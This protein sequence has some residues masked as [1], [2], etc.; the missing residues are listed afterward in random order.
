MKRILFALLFILSYSSL[1][2]QNPAFKIGVDSFELNGKPF[3]IHCGE[4]HFAR[5]P[6]AEW[7]NRLKM[8]KE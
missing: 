4:M 3:V 2:A 6:K 5:I 7:R 8:A 1:F